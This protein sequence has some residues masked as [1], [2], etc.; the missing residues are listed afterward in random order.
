M[1]AESIEAEFENLRK[2]VRELAGVVSAQ[3]RQI[4]ALRD[5]FECV[6]SAAAIARQLTRFDALKAGREPTVPVVEVPAERPHAWI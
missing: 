4:E 3:Q 2:A 6:S 1:S 5:P